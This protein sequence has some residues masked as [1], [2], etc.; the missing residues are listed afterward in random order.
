MEVQT[1]AG[2]VNLLEISITEL[3]NLSY[4][5]QAPRADPHEAS[6]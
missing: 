6:R 3:Q 2:F 4:L 1:G 5:F